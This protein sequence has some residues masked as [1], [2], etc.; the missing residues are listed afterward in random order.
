MVGSWVEK[1][2]MLDVMCGRLSPMAVCVECSCKAVVGMRLIGVTDATGGGKCSVDG[3]CARTG[4]GVLTSIPFGRLP[5]G[6]VGLSV[7]PLRS[8]IP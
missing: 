2:E 6:T 7:S 4:D 1:F 5:W 8:H 3:R